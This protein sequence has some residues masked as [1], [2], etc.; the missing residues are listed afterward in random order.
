M[1]VI[2]GIAEDPFIKMAARAQAKWVRY[3]HKRQRT[4]EKRSP[5]GKVHTRAN[6]DRLQK[7]ISRPSKAP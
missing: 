6:E 2:K 3:Y 7:A 4:A 1:R 5:F